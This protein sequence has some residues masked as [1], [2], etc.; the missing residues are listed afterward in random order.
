MSSDRIVGL[1]ARVDGSRLRRLN[2]ARTDRP[3][4]CRLSAIE[5]VNVLLL[6]LNLAANIIERTCGC[7]RPV[8]VENMKAREGEKY[9]KH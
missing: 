4:E 7:G 1:T 9:T 2:C 6:G 5:P 8:E 3:P